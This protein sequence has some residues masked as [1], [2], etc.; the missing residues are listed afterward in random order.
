MGYSPYER[1]TKEKYGDI[2][3]WAK[4]SIGRLWDWNFNTIGAWSSHETFNKGMP[5]TIIMNIGASAGSD[6]LKGSFPDVFSGNFR[7]IA[8]KI[9]SEVCK[10]YA[11]EPFLFGY[12]T[13]NELRWGADW[14]SSKTLFDDFLAMPK[15]LDGKKALV[16]TFM[17][18]Y[19]SIDKLNS[20]LNTNLKDFD[21]LLSI[22]DLSQL[23]ESPKLAE[24]SEKWKK[25]FILPEDLIILYL[26]LFYGNIYNVNKAFGTKA[27]DFDELLTDDFVAMIIAE[28]RK[29][30]FPKEMIIAGLEVI[31]GSIE[32]ANKEFNT[33]A[34]TYDELVEYFTIAQ[35]SSSVVLEIKKNKEHLLKEDS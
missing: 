32:N 15:D 29:Q 30:N 12:F 24:L 6:W 28:I 35:N 25:D 19:G 8:E 10:S 4:A 34:K 16:K 31:Y 13:D 23:G 1:V 7:N 20:A 33:N 2:N 18:V 22:T 17:E 21:D 9:A 14:R 27:K 3:K 11:N 5:Y 26:N